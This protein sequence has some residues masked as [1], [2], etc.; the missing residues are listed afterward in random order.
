MDL[1]LILIWILAIKVFAVGVIDGELRMTV[2]GIWMVFV[3][4]ILSW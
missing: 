2:L 4:S 1:I 3:A